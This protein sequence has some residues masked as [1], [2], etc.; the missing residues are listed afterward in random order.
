MA[1]ACGALLGPRSFSNQM[2]HFHRLVP[3]TIAS[4]VTA[5]GRWSDH[6][7]DPFRRS[8]F[9]TQCP[10]RLNIPDAWFLKRPASVKCHC[11]LCNRDWC[12]GCG[13]LYHFHL[14]CEEAAEATRVWRQFVS[15][16][17]GEIGKRYKDAVEK[18]ERDKVCRWLCF[19]GVILGSSTCRGYL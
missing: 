13:K 8:C 18:F 11:H 12:L 5:P 3:L 2:R 9:G 4:P 6:P 7:L 17:G 10:A 1:K 14:Q 19:S 16:Q 15:E